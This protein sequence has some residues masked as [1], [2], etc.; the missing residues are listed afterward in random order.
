[1]SFR[2]GAGLLAVSLV[3]F[4]S[5]STSF[6]GLIMH[7]D[8]SDLS[9]MFEDGNTG[10]GTDPLDPPFIGETVR[11]IESQVNGFDIQQAGAGPILGAGPGGSKPYVLDFN[12]GTQNLLALSVNAGNILS[13]V[14]ELNTDT[15]TII[16]AGRANADAAGL[17]T[18]INLNYVAGFGGANLV[19]LEYDHDANELIGR[20]SGGSVSAAVAEGKWFVAELVWDGGNGVS[21]SVDGALAGTDASSAVAGI[22]F[23]RSRIGRA[24]SNSGTLNGSVGDVY[25]F[26]SAAENNGALIES[27]VA[28]YAVP[29]PSGLSLVVCVLLALATAAR[30]QLRHV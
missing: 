13:P 27:L 4:N 9:R 28:A 17:S 21:L 16:L 19:S 30:L 24:A 7:F 8:P 11:W 6:G 29:E 5:S 25:I 3:V 12:G 22:D 23:D 14:T 2:F 10:G 18:F 15:L 26:D 20:A 1:M